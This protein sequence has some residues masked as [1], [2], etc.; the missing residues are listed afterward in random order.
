MKKIFQTT[1]LLIIALLLSRNIIYAQP[2]EM[3][4]GN[5]ANNKN[6][7]GFYNEIFNEVAW[8]FKTGSAV[9]SSAIVIKDIICFGSSDGY[10][11]AL[12]KKDTV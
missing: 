3:F 9:R 6:Y 7:T 8:K 1:H 5:P 10:L 11:Y 2:D 12:N 4:R